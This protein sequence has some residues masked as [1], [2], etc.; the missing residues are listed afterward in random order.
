[1]SLPV[2]I[3]RPR[4]GAEGTASR[5]RELGF[6]PIVDPLFEV[7]PINWDPPD[8]GL[9]DSLLLTSANA[10][11]FAGDALQEYSGLPVLAVGDRTA[12]AARK[13]GLDVV[14]TGDGGA[15]DLIGQLPTDRYSRILRLTGKDHVVLD[16]GGREIV[17]CKVYR[18][19]ALSLGPNARKAIA[20]GCAVLLFS[21]RAARI[22]ESELRSAEIS[23][24]HCHALAL[25][26]NIASGLA[27]A[28][29]G[30]HVAEQPTED[31][32]LSLLPPLCFAP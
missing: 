17:S 15:A 7:E 8:S 20:E 5:V 6:E 10:V 24:I 25:S 31:A 1:M 9:F 23:P 32:L 26:D 28:W 11:R 19:G 27:L 16:P 22:V 12:E 29:K 13:A 18:A 30:L 14:E 2:L 3:L 4:D 21:V